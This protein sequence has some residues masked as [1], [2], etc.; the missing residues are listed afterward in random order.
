MVKMPPST[1]LDPKIMGTFGP[2][3]QGWAG[4]V[5]PSTCGWNP[6]LVGLRLL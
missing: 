3:D 6:K 2:I 4:I 1:E 5:T